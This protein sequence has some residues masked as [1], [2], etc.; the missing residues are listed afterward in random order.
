MHRFILLV[1]LLEFLSIP[2]LAMAGNEKPQT[3]DTEQIARG[4]VDHFLDGKMQPLLDHASPELRALIKDA[5]TMGTIRDQTVG[6]ATQPIEE[7]ATVVY[8]RTVKSATGQTWAVTA[9]V[10]ADGQLS[11][12]L[13]QPAGEAPSKFLDYK[14]KADVRLPF[15][16]QWNVFWGGRT[17]K[18]NYHAVSEGQRFAYDILMM[19]NGKT[20]NGNGN[21]N[22]DYYCYGQTI[23]AP[24]SGLVVSA[25]DGVADNIPG[26]MNPAELCGNH[27]VLDLGNDE[28]LF[29]AHLQNGSVK[30]KPGDRVTQGQPLGLCGNSGNSSEPHL[31]IH[32]QT[33]ASLEG[34]KGLPLEFQHYEAD[35]K[36]IDRGEPTKGQAIRNV[37]S[38]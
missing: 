33:T 37:V 2:M 27:V 6:K 22:E 35:G 34:G 30:V 10:A 38:K 23:V 11:G 14:T 13:I 9:T 25:I 7:Q 28:F 29:L 19:K 18:E 4:Y 17:I 20:H 16:G 32:L 15:D 1:V 5:K 8:S 36:T 12:F 26:K 24:A 3:P 31:H 21:C